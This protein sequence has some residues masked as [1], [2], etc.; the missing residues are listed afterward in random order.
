MD[1]VVI[2]INEDIHWFLAIVT[3]PR[4]AIVGSAGSKSHTDIRIE[5]KAHIV[6]LDSLH[7][8]T[9]HRRKLLHWLITEYLEHEYNDKRKLKAA[10]DEKFDRNQVDLIYPRCV[11]QQKNYTDC[12]LFMLKYTECFLVNPPMLIV[13]TD[14]FRSWYPRFNILGMRSKIFGKLKAMCDSAKWK[15]YEEYSESHVTDTK[16]DESLPTMSF[17]DNRSPS[18]PPRSRSFSDSDRQEVA[19]ENRRK[20]SLSS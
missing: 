14:S 1:Y 11:P 9:D 15:L 2:P 10:R 12:G 7:D 4:L 16:H 13:R 18:P 6:I 8:E 20:R 19:E 3:F 17:L 5:R